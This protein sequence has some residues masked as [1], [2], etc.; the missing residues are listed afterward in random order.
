MNDMDGTVEDSV[1]YWLKDI[2]LTIN[3]VAVAIE[4]ETEALVRIA[5]AL[6]RIAN[7]MDPDGRHG[8]YVE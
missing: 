6:D 4:A 7:A 2:S 5:N 8:R 1:E 3:D